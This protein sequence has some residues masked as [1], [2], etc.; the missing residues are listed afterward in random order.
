MNRPEQTTVTAQIAALQ[1]MTVG[2]LREKWKELYGGE[3]T[4]SFNR[5]YLWRRLAWRVQELAFGGLSERARARIAELNKGDDL[6]FLPPRTWNPE[7]LL[8]QDAP[9]QQERRPIRDPRLPSPG[10]SIARQYHGQEIRVTVLEKGFEWEGRPYRSLSAIA[11]E[12]TAQR[13]NGVLF[14]GL[15]D[16]KRKS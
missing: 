10:A 16:R 6:R 9:S 11:R 14:F 7:V 13:W 1:K 2:Q 8:S 3:E 4:R 12:V 15:T 5:V